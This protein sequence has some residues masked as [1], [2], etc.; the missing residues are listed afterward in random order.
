MKPPASE[1]GRRG[2]GARGL[3][4]AIALLSVLGCSRSDAPDAQTAVRVHSVPRGARIF[5]DGRAAGAATPGAISLQVGRT[6]TI[7]VSRDGYLSRPEARTVVARKD[8][9]PLRFE[10]VPKVDLH[11]ETDP[12]GAVITLD[13]RRLGQAPLTAPAE[14]DVPHDITV[15]A[16]D[17]LERRLVWNGEDDHRVRVELEPAVR[18]DV[19]SSPSPASVLIDGEPRGETPTLIDVPAS[20]RFVLVARRPGYRDARR[21]LDGRRLAHGDTVTLTLEPLRLSALRLSAPER[22]E[23]RRL[24]RELSQLE[25]RLRRT[26]ALNDQSIRR[27]EQIGRGGDIHTTARLDGVID[28]TSDRIEELE[29]AIE[30]LQGRLEAYRDFAAPPAV[31]PGSGTTGSK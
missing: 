17:Y 28:A 16:T 18:I 26:R 23:V 13:G 2:A 1:R 27:L 9:E 20:R 5:V 25:S 12:S 6:H 8:G 21:P 7:T 15:I 14:R 31:E 4:A 24:Q 3:A 10:L 11:I 29:L 19:S 30:D 22:G